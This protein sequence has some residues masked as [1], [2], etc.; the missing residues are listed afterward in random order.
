MEAVIFCGIQA[1]G[2]STFFKEHFFA[3][4]MRI[5]LDLFNTRN[6][7]DRFLE[8]CFTTSQKFVVDNT[9]ASKLER[10]KYIIMARLNRYKVI[11]YYF[12][13][14]LTDALERNSTRTGK[15][16]IPEKGVKG[17][18]NRLQLPR[19][20]EGFDEL[21]FVSIENNQFIIQPWKDEI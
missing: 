10:E 2:K 17:T 4:H 19:R 6:R 18:Y 13:S 20:S 11:G 21:Y 16:L 9:N 14:S 15:A 1:T 3:T 5:S 8:T 7:E 12:S